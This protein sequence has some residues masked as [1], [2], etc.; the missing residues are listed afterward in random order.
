MAQTIKKTVIIGAG[1][2][3][4]STACHLKDSYVLIEKDSTPGGMASSEYV[5]GFIFDKAGH[6]LHFKIDYAKK[7]I[8]SIIG[9]STISRHK[10]LSW[11]YSKNTYTRY[12]FQINTYKLPPD[13]IRDCLLK[14]A[15]TQPVI[16]KNKINNL[17][18][19]ILRNFGEGIAI[20]FMFPYNR[21]LW[22]T[23]LNTIGI[24]WVDKFIPKAQ[25]GSAIKGAISD[26]KRG[27]GYN[28]IF[29]YP[30]KGG[31]Q[32]VS[33]ALLSRVQNKVFFNTKVISV[34]LK[35]RTVTLSS[36]KTVGFD[37]IVSTMPLPELRKTRKNTPPD[38]KDKAN[39]LRHVSVFNLNL[40][41]DRGNISDKHWIY[42]PE[43]KFIF[44]RVGFFSNFS[45]QIAPGEKSSLYA[46][47]SYTKDK[48]LKYQLNKLKRKI[49]QDLNRTGILKK[50]DR[51]LAEKYYNI[52]YAYP[53]C[54]KNTF[55]KVI[56]EFLKSHNIYSIGRYGSWRYLSMEES[57]IQGKLT[58]EHINNVQLIK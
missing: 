32:T 3:G 37:R 39:R 28:R 25:L 41:I 34:C 30:D 36:G 19:W 56:D 33:D 45:N 5:K 35:S 11:I 27:F 18:D 14:M 31:I 42:F 53:V 26:F 10:R 44:Y 48:P 29:Y 40:G 38:I 57:I 21:K 4:L 23:P 13:V 54:S 22:K 12:P 24:D 16:K 7:F 52:K 17:R 2:T 58:A 15:E 50:D 55:T 46:E 9:R 47:V 51:I 20:H 6:L 8:F 1:L 49:I 43:N